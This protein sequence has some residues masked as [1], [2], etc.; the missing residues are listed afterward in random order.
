M[1]SVLSMHVY[2]LKQAVDIVNGT[3]FSFNSSV[4]P[5]NVTSADMNYC[6]H[7]VYVHHQVFN[8]KLLIEYIEYKYIEI[9]VYVPVLSKNENSSWINL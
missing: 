3:E 8:C 2:D 7:N 9:H 4:L 1:L 6:S 5:E